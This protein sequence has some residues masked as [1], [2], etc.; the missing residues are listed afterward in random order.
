MELVGQILLLADPG[1]LTLGDGIK[2]LASLGGTSIMALGLVAMVKRWLITPFELDQAN[3]RTEL[4]RVERDEWKAL[5]LRS[6]DNTE[7]LGRAAAQAATVIGEQVK[8]GSDNG[9]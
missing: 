7:H 5:A 9:E 2:W 3:K 8:R 6:I 4:M 1:G